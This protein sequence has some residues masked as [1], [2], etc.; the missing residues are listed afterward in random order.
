MS[1]LKMSVYEN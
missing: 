1:C